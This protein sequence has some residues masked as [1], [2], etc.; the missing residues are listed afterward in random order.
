M[1]P[2][3]LVPR[4]RL[5]LRGDSIP[6][7][8]LVKLPHVPASGTRMPAGLIAGTYLGTLDLASLMRLSMSD[9]RL[10][11]WARPSELAE[12]R[13]R[14][15]N[16]FDLTCES[17]ESRQLLST[18]AIPGTDPSQI[19]ALPSLQVLPLV[20]TGPTGSVRPSRLQS[21]YGVN[22]ITFSGGKVVGN[23]AG[24]TIAIVTAYNDPN[25]TSDLA[26][27]DKQYRLHGPDRRRSQSRTWADRRPMPAGRSRHRSTS[28]GPMP[29]RPAAK[30]LL[31]EASSASLSGLFS[32]VS[33]ASKQ[34]GVSVVSMSWGTTEFWG[35]WNL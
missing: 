18:A 24:Q 25:I 17:L 7:V 29:W 26:A 20:A 31:V 28:S 4:F 32:A 6:P 23:G 22:Q 33:Y 34:A 9:T 12:F 10:S 13:I 16:R 2:R 19:T 27:F 3:R 30:I 15:R 21:A 1:N 8:F 11:A 35:Q 14:Q 5:L